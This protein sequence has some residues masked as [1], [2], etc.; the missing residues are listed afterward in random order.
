MQS[1]TLIAPAKINL[2]LEIIRDRPDGY[3]ELLMIL[4][5]IDLADRL[6]ICSH[7]TQ[8]FRLTC[9]NPQVPTN[10]TNLAYRAAQLMK[11]EFGEA[12]ANYGGV[13]ITIDKRI[14]VAA[15]LAGGSTNAA[16]VLVGLNLIWELGLTIP[17]LQRLGE[18]LGSD[19]PFCIAG[20]T[21][22]ATGRG[23]K[24]V[25]IGDLNSLWV[26]LGKYKSLAVSTAW[27]YQT[28]RQQ[29]SHEYIS[30]HAVV[31]SRISKVHSDP[32]I[33]AISHKDNHKIGQLLHNDLEKVVLPEYSQV[34]K[35]RAIL[36]Q[37]GGLGTMMS[38]SGP[39]VFTLC[40]SQQE[41][42]NIKNKARQAIFD[43]DLELLITK[44][45]STGI[46]VV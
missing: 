40:Q 42:E 15:G 7:G 32:L 1:Y 43:P 6:E 16:A 36:E 38:G 34:M 19:V 37:I 21:V 10:E 4:Q 39:T 23:E 9:S 29:F 45:S 41:A 35:L 25:P 31:T 2:Y 27:A 26:I 3:H 24:L 5:S 14:P 18:K 28:Y 30:D 33:Q 20:G 46:Q 13:D 17:E 22:V 12:F 44:L 11:L 8:D